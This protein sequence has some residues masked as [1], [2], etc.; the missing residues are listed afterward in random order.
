MSVYLYVFQFKIRNLFF[1]IFNLKVIE[2]LLK[3]LFNGNIS[4]LYSFYLLFSFLNSFYILLPILNLLIVLPKYSR[5]FS[6]ILQS[7]IGKTFFDSLVVISSISFT[8]PNI[9]EEFLFGP[10]GVSLFQKRIFLFLIFGSK[11]RRFGL[12][13]FHILFLVSL[14]LLIVGFLCLK[15]IQLFIIKELVVITP[16]SL[17]SPSLKLFLFFSLGWHV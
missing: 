9:C 5:V 10:I 8:L 16:V 6:N 7:L 11:S 13:L 17:C 2:Q 4:L 3:L 12:I 1:R 14:I 15:C